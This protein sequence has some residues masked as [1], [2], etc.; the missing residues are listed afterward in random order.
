MADLKPP[1]RLYSIDLLPA[2]P[3]QQRLQKLIDWLTSDMEADRF[4]VHLTLL[5]LPDLD[6]ENVRRVSGCIRQL[7]REGK[8]FELDILGPGTRQCY[9]Q[10]LFATVALTDELLTIRRRAE[11]LV[12][13]GRE[14]IFLPHFSLLYGDYPREDKLGFAAELMDELPATVTMDRVTL[15][16]AYG[17][18]REW[19]DV[20]AFPLGKL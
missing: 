9:F 17:Y 20:A 10:C 16:R 2:P 19:C 14:S 11:W 8:P 5:P 6:E 1:L 15:C 7:A 3:E 12:G 13:L 18:P 4:E